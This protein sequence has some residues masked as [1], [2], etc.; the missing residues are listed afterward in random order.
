[1]INKEFNEC[2]VAYSNLTK[3]AKA[4]LENLLIY[5]TITDYGFRGQAK[6]NLFNK[7]VNYRKEHF[8][9]FPDTLKE[10]DNYYQEYRSK[11]G[12]DLINYN[13]PKSDELYEIF[14]NAM[15]TE[16]NIDLLKEYGLY[17][18]IEADDLSND[19]IGN[20]YGWFIKDPQ[21]DIIKK[22]VM[23]FAGTKGKG[24]NQRYVFCLQD[25]P[26]VIEKDFDKDEIMDE[27]INNVVGNTEYDNNWKGLILSGLSNEEELQKFFKTGIFD[28]PEPNNER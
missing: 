13:E 24:N 16:T 10:I 4:K 22:E 11:D 27:E 15:P 6:I 8:T 1:M 14:E 2:D 18:K 19:K 12:T 20:A 26:D 7:I 5:K 21:T 23:I 28:S 25:G 9:R 17:K 3:D